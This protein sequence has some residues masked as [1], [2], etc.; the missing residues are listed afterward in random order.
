MAGSRPKDVDVLELYDAFTINT[1]LFLED[2]GFCK[3]GEGGAFVSGGRIAPGGALPSIPTAEAFRASIPGCTESFD[4]RGSA[5]LQGEKRRAPGP[6][7]RKS[8]SRTATAECCPARSRP[9]SNRGNLMTDMSNIKLESLR[10]KVSSQ[11]G[12]IAARCR[13]VQTGLVALF[14]HEHPSL[15]PHL[16]RVPG[17]EGHVPDQPVR[18]LVRRESPHSS[19][20]KIATSTASRCSI[21]ALARRQPRRVL[22]PKRVATRAHDVGSVIS[23]ANPS[24]MAISALK[25]WLLPIH[26]ERNVLRGRDRV[27]TTTNGPGSPTPTSSSG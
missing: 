25:C 20:V 16:G 8:R 15:H 7:T 26:P 27:T 12:Q 4:R 19:L 22:I 14:R 24:G 1:I 23:H 11:N 13:G 3:K 18:Q 6:A 5:T 17:E 2:L 9:C 21:R 10:G